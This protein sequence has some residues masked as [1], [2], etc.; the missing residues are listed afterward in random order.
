MTEISTE[1]PR[2]KER[3]KKDFCKLFQDK[4]NKK[5]VSFLDVTLDLTS[6]QHIPY[7]TL[8]SN[9]EVLDKAIPVYQKAVE[10]PRPEAKNISRKRNDFWYNHPYYQNLKTNIGRE[11]LKILDN[12]F[13]A[14]NKLHKIFIRNTV[15]IPYSFMPSMKTIIVGNNK[16]L[17]KTSKPRMQLPE[18]HKI[19]KCA[20]TL[21]V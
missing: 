14:T 5:V 18:K 12:C 7:I 3:M 17:L 10:K 8:S 20:C 21:R 16:K 4:A 9:E 15:K 13:P 11:F 2:E 1:T 6:G 19:R